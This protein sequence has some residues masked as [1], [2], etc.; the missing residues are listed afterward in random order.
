MSKDDMIRHFTDMLA[1]KRTKIFSTSLIIMEI[2]IETN[3]KY[4]LSEWLK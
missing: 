2:Q 3:M 1:D 4:H